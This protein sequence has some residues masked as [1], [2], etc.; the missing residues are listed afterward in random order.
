MTPLIDLAESVMSAHG[1]AVRRQRDIAKAHLE[2][3]LIAENETAIVFFETV[4][5]Q[6]LRRRADE[7]AAAVAAVTLQPAAGPKA[8]EAYLVLLVTEGYSAHEVAADAVQRDLNYCRKVVVDGA[9]IA[10][11]PD[12]HGAMEAALS[13]LFPLDVAS[14]PS[15]GDVRQHLIELISERGIDAI[16][17]RELVNAFDAEADCRCWE[18]IMHVA[19]ATT[20]E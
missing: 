10:D 12:P 13:F 1:W 5:G 19:P 11:S 8:W 3:D 7:L 18:R 9:A 2:F 6:R 17:V 20:S 14:A 4:S 16:L 15:V